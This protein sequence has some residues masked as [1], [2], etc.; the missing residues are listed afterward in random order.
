MAPVH[1]GHVSA[2]GRMAAH[3]VPAATVTKIAE[4]CLEA[5][6]CG[7]T[8]YVYLTDLEDECSYQGTV[9]L[10]AYAEPA[11]AL[12]E[13]YH[14]VATVLERS[15]LTWWYEALLERALKKEW[16]RAA[17][18]RL[19][20]NDEHREAVHAKPPTKTNIIRAAY[21]M[22]RYWEQGGRHDGPNACYEIKGGRVCLL[23]TRDRP[24][25]D[26]NTKLLF[27]G[28]RRYPSKKMS[29]YR[30]DI[31]RELLAAGVCA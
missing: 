18:R 17:A 9:H 25:A 22:R 29:K 2:I 1:S 21:D 19:V 20:K 8:R 5:N 13:H 14:H 11:G 7:H 28:H 24:N 15:S 10:V 12:P 31:C 23:V 3:G 16:P 26:S 30:D 4:R 6:E 27:I